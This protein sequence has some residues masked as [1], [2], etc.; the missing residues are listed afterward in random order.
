MSPAALDELRQTLCGTF[1]SYHLKEVGTQKLLGTVSHPVISLHVGLRTGASVGDVRPGKGS[2]SC[3]FGVILS[4]TTR[5][6][7]GPDLLRSLF[8]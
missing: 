3:R 1:I 7:S 8:P 2:G 4:D 5:M 6:S